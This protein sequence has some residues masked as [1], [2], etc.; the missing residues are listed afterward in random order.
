MHKHFGFI[1]YLKVAELYMGHESSGNDNVCQHLVK[2]S[3]L[4]FGI[5]WA[6]AN[7]LLRLITYGSTKILFA[8]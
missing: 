1:Y 3:T 2:I 7:K 6:K 5:T 8:I 4:L